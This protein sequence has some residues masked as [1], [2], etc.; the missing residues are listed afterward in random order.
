MMV[1]VVVGVGGK[2]SSDHH[3]YHHLLHT[4]REMTR[5]HWPVEYDGAWERFLETLFE[6][7]HKD[8]DALHRRNGLRAPILG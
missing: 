4:M 3:G 5:R 2:K 1:A 7:F 8:L 6:L